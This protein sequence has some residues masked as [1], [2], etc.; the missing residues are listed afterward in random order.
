MTKKEREGSGSS[1]DSAMDEETKEILEEMEAEGIDTSTLTGGKKVVE[2]NDHKDKD[3]EDGESESDEDEDESED[4][5]ESEEEGDDKSKDETEETDEDEEDESEEEEED[6][7][8]EG[9]KSKGKLSIVQKYRREQKLR[10][11]AESTLAELQSK[12]TD[13]AFD[14]ELESF[15]KDSHMNIDVAKKFLELAAKKAG[16]PKDLMDDLQKSRKEH[17]NTEYW[18]TQ[19]K[20]FDK[21]FKS[22]V[23]P[24]LESL[25]KSEEEIEEILETLNGDDKSPYWAWNEKN[26]ST[27]LV[28][29]ALDLTRKGTSSRTSSEGTGSKHLNRGKS[30]KEIDDMTPEDINSMSD[31]EFAEWSDKLG[32]NSKSVVSRR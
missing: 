27:S 7:E 23:R 22:N 10:K 31:K 8:D 30:N 3:T 32:K 28:K 24:V 14:K 1:D 20:A 19:R 6:D 17:R 21:D 18:D 5:S 13:E 16:L 2:A 4:E 12:N 29:L 25:K 26:K 11:A 15:A 9:N